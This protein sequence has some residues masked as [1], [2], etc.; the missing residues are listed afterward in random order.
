MPL[1]NPQIVFSFNVSSKIVGGTVTWVATSGAPDTV[2]IT[3]SAITQFPRRLAAQLQPGTQDKASLLQSNIMKWVEGI[4]KN[5]LP[6]AQS[7]SI[8]GG[9]PQPPLT[10]RVIELPAD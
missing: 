9:A 8:G 4:Q 5:Q 2:G 10:D 6:V 3:G 7:T 1:N